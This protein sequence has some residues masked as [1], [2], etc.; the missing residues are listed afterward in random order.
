MCWILIQNNKPL[1]ASAFLYCCVHNNSSSALIWGQL[2]TIRRVCLLANFLL[3][4][5][6]SSA[7]LALSSTRL[8]RWVFTCLRQSES[9]LWSVCGMHVQFC[10]KHLN[11]FR[12]FVFFLG[13]SRRVCLFGFR[14]CCASAFKYFFLVQALAKKCADF[15]VLNHSWR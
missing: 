2:R 7:R 11:A 5:V 1:R 10:F 13:L 14:R 15:C 6:V 12:A 3:F 4:L 8:F 9:F